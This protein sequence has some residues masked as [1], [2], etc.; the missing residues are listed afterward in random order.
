MIQCDEEDRE[1][2]STK[3]EREF[4]CNEIVNSRFAKNNE[5]RV[6]PVRYLLSRIAWRRSASVVYSTF[7][8]T[9]LFSLS[10]CFISISF[11]SEFV[12]ELWPSTG[13]GGVVRASGSPMAVL[14]WWSDVDV[15]VKRGTIREKDAK[16]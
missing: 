3:H 6:L 8:P 5:M 16:H 11:A 12:C 15:E 1:K 4:L 10:A 7:P 2:H 13:G 9:V 14:R